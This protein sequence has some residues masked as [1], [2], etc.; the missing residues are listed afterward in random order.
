MNYKKWQEVAVMYTSEDDMN[1]KL[2]ECR[3]FLYEN[4]T[5]GWWYASSR[6]MKEMSGIF[7]FFIEDDN[8]ATIFKL[9]FN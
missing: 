4:T 5:C 6:E 7:K 3:E 1:K 9:K 8:D 2:K